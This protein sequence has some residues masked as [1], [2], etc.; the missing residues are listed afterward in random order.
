MLILKMDVWHV[1]IIFHRK[2]IQPN[3]ELRKK[4]SDKYKDNVDFKFM[5]DD[6]VF[7]EDKISPQKKTT[8]II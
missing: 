7:L 8:K 4:L 3:E 5:S 1:T 6:G 2:P